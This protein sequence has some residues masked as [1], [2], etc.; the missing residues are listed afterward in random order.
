M[1][2]LPPYTPKVWKTL[3]IAVGLLIVIGLVLFTVQQCGNWREQRE[4]D[5]ARANVNAA[6]SNLSNAQANKVQ[7]EKD[8]AIAEQIAKDAAQD[9]VK[10]SEASEEAKKV[11]NQALANITVAQGVNT[12]NTNVQTL[13]DILDKLDEKK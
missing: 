3:A 11:T 2:I 5:K 12:Q 4:I 6:L 7:A 10:A 13:K 8:L 9:V 1:N